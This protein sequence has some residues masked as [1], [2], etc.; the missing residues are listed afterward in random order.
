MARRTK[1]EIA[2]TIIDEIQ[3]NPAEPIV[4]LVIQKD[5]QG[6]YWQRPSTNGESI[7]RHTVI[8]QAVSEAVL[9]DGDMADFGLPGQSF[10]VV[11]EVLEVPVVAEVVVSIEGDVAIGEFLIPG[12]AEASAIDAMPIAMGV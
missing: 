10:T 7:K 2:A 9:A 5:E 11:N 12:T 6:Y 8:D 3:E 4:T 1:A